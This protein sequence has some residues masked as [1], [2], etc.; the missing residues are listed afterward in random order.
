M[1]KALPMAFAAAFGDEKAQEDAE[2]MTEQMFLSAI[3]DPNAPVATTFRS[4]P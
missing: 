3:A 4:S 1:G 2:K